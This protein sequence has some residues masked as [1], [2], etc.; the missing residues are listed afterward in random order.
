MRA[1][2]QNGPAQRWQD[3]ARGTRISGHSPGACR[4]A[5]SDVPKPAGFG[6][7]GYRD[8]SYLEGISA[9]LADVVVAE[10]A[11]ID[12]GPASWIAAN[13]HAVAAA[14][15]SATTDQP[16]TVAML[17]QWQ[18]TL[19]QGSPLPSRYVGTIRDEQGWIGGS[20]P[21]DAALVTP[22]PAHVPGLLNDLVAYANR[23]DLDPIAQTAFAHAQFEIIHPFADGNGRV[24]RVLVS[25]L[26]TRRLALIAP[27]PVSA[28]MAADRG[29]YL[30]GLTQFRLGMHDLWVDWFADTVTGAGNAQK[31]LVT[32]LSELQERWR[33]QIRTTIG[34]QRA[35]R[36]DSVAWRILELLPRHLVLTPKIVVR[37]SGRSERA[38]QTALEQLRRVPMPLRR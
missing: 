21:L 23:T 37:E 5:A 34:A 2:C 27:P 8:P 33:F 31:S 10:S 4:R 26:L 32:E 28:R 38:A 22:P 13:M 19:V 20:S 30:A 14:I 9:P 16:M 18:G 29:G 24:G 6:T 7:Q 35:L 3:S 15:D 25:W 36:T 12:G 1:L 11:N 17:C